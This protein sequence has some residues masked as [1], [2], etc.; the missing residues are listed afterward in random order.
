MSSNKLVIK[1]NVN[2]DNKNQ[3]KQL[4]IYSTQ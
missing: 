2:N 3:N 4:R 1:N